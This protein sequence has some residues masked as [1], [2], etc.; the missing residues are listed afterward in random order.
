MFRA[1]FSCTEG[2]LSTLRKCPPRRPPVRCF[3]VDCPGAGRAPSAGRG[4]TSS[5]SGPRQRT[6]VL[7][8]NAAHLRSR[9]ATVVK[10]S[11]DRGYRLVACDVVGED[12]A[13]D[14]A[15]VMVWEG[16]ECVKRL[17]KLS[18]AGQPEYVASSLHGPLH[19]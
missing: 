16:D 7:L 12:G 17:G 19:C 4:S 14:S 9:V 13:P 11:E 3:A 8:S 5:N 15:L 6:V 18:A 1:T 2:V 10:V